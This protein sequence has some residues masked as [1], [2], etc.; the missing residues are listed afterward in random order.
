MKKKTFYVRK[1]FTTYIELRVSAVNKEDAMEQADEY[2]D[3]NCDE[4]FENLEE[5]ET[6]CYEC[7][8]TEL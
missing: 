3:E 4:L 1:C 2:A 7:D 8:D 6:E 5:D